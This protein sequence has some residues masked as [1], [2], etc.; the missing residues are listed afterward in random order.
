MLNF[1]KS[2]DQLFK[3]K[4]SEEYSFYEF[5]NQKAAFGLKAAFQRRQSFT[6]Q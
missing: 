5:C 2:I 1:T 3:Y 6:F 4:S